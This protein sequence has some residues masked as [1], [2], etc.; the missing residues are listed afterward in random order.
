MAWFMDTY[1]QHVGHPTPGIVTGKPT[2]LGG[3]EGRK[4]ATGLGATICA[5]AMV[6]RLGRSNAS[7]QRY[8]GG[9]VYLNAQICA[10]GQVKSRRDVECLSLVVKLQ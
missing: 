2:V 3:T 4:A 6:E 5:E 10:I 9:L 7:A 1:S 8:W